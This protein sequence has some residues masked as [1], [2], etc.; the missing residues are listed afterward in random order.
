MKSQMCRGAQN[1]FDSSAPVALRGER[2]QGA[3]RVTPCRRHRQ[4]SKQRPHSSLMTSSYEVRVDKVAHLLHCGV[5][6]SR[7]HDGRW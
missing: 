4:A 6:A 1:F 3:A 7:A 2:S 5:R